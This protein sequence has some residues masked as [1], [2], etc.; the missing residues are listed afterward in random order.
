MYKTLII[1]DMQNDFTDLNCL[2]TNEAQA[3]IPNVIKKIKE[4]ENNGDK[5]IFTQDTHDEDYLET[6]EGKHLP[7]PH[8]IKN[9]DGWNISRDIAKEINLSKYDSFSKKT[10][11]SIDLAQYLFNNKYN[12]EEIEIIGLVSSIC[13]ISNALILKTICPEVKII[14]DASCIAGI[15]NDDYLASLKIMEMCQIKI[16]NKVDNI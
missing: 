10:F 4:Y 11:G 6:Q 14:V 16:I 7:V 3:I 13:V 1:V 5:I 8:C 2:G 9:T 15:N 12:F